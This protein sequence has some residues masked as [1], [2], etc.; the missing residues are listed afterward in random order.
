MDTRGDSSAVLVVWS[1]ASDDV[2][3][4]IRTALSFLVQETGEAGHTPSIDD[5]FITLNQGSARMRYCPCD[6]TVIEESIEL[7]ASQG[8]KQILVVPIVLVLDAAPHAALTGEIPARIGEVNARHP[9]VDVVYLGPPFEPLHRI[10][11]FLT[12]AREHAPEAVDLLKG[13]IARGFKNDWALFAR[14]M[15]KLQSVLPVDT[16]VALRG[17]AVTG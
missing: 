7:G 8:Y 4:P 15:E 13:A 1:A 14:F 17:S 6:P 5:F 2:L 11:S 16:R 9:D 10:H 3:S 12:M